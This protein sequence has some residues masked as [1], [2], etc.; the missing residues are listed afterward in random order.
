MQEKK[1]K[2]VRAQVK[3]HA[4]KKCAQHSA[5]HEA[6]VA[7]EKVEAEAWQ[8]MTRAFEKIIPG[9]DTTA[10]WADY[11]L[12]FEAWRGTRECRMQAM[13][14]ERAKYMRGR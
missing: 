1:F 2:Q 6:L 3:R 4:A 13:R 11:H 12:A 5:E 7:S 8:T 14:A 10:S 9:Q